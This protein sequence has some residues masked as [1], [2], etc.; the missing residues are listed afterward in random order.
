[1]QLSRK[2]LVDRVGGDSAGAVCQGLPVIGEGMG[3]SLWRPMGI[4]TTMFWFS[5][6]LGVGV[7]YHTMG[8]LKATIGRGGVAALGKAQVRG[9]SQAQSSHLFTFR[10]LA[11]LPKGHHFV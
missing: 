1:V 3:L 4:G 8:S 11:G 2:R 5:R 9:E 7:K 10:L 6:G